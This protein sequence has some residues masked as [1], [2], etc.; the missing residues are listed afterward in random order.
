MLAVYKAIELWGAP[1]PL[2]GGRLILHINNT[3]VV[4]GLAKHS[5]KG[6]AMN[7]LRRLLVKAAAFDLELVPCWIPTAENTLADALSRQEWRKIA[8]LCPQLTQ[9]NLTRLTPPTAG[10]QMSQTST[11]KLPVSLVGPC[12]VYP[13][14]LW[15]RPS[16]L[17]PILRSER[18]WNFSFPSFSTPSS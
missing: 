7:T 8:D 13:Q 16:Q 11:G 5:I 2:L 14:H 4:G 6:K 1:G 15:H 17:H 12:P 18:D 3:A 10:T 9:K